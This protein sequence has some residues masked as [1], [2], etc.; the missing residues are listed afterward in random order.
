MARR[1]TQIRSLGTML[2]TSV[3]AER[4][5]P[6]ITTRSPVARTF[7]NRSRN[8]P[9]CP[10]GLARMRTSA[11]VGASGV[12]QAMAASSPIS[13]VDRIRMS[14]SVPAF[15]AQRRQSDAGGIETAVDREN[16]PGDVARPL[17]AQEEDGLRQ[18]LFEAIAIERDRI[19]IIGADL[20]CV[21]GFR[22]RSV[23]RP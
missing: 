3:Q 2:S 15:T 7:S 23:D 17:A 9:T 13:H 11:R 5:G 16:L 20:R 14:L 8:G 19:V 22:H 4:Q 12:A 1:V 6:S 18:F 10:P 21:H